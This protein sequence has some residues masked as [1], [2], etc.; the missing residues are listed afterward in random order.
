MKN[1]KIYVLF[2]FFFTGIIES[3]SDE[4][5]E[6]T[7]YGSLSEDTYFQTP[8]AA[9]KM[10]ANCYSPMLADFPFSINKGAMG[11]EITDDADVGGSDPGDRP[12]IPNVATGRPLTSNPL[13]L[14]TWT[15]RYDGI[16]KCNYGISGISREDILLR[17]AEGNAVSEGTKLRYIAEI[18][19]LRAFYY[20]DLVTAFKNVPLLTQPASI[21]DKNKI[22]KSP[23]EALRL[24]IL[25]DLEEGIAEPNLPRA[26][27]M[28]PEELGRVSKDAVYAFKVRVT[29]FFAGLIEQGLMEGDANEEY[30][31]ARNA[32][33]EVIDN[34]G[35]ELMNDYQNLF[36]GDYIEGT[37]SKECIF[38]VLRT[39]IGDIWFGGDAFAIMN[40]GR[41]EV[42][43]WGGNC[44]TR[45]L[46]AE[47][48][49]GDP[50]KLYTIISHLDT[51][52]RVS[53]LPEIHDYSGYYNDFNLQQSRKAFV[54]DKYR[55]E[56]ALERTNWSPYYIRY[57][58]VLL[59]YAEA[60]LKTSGDHQ[61]VADLINQVR[62]RAF[63]TT[64]KIDEEATYR[65]FHAE[66]FPIDDAMFNNTYKV[67]ASDD[68]LA[69][70]KHERR[71]ELGMESLR[72][73]D[74]LRW[75]D[76]VPVMNS[77]YDHYGLAN[78]GKYVTATSWPFPI[79]Q[80]E[81][82]RAGGSL[83]QTPNY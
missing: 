63:V 42:G 16:G 48:E 79:P 31:A 7:Q 80:V 81:I 30:L 60:L 47:F 22:E 32:A 82:D 20:F 62:Y 61:T 54:P 68:L 25:K 5:L 52:P 3:C 78:K 28:P 13:L 55:D 40:A 77:F 46:A 21:E 23:I 33:A 76:Y 43:G 8:D 71:V 34:G 57:A 74:L 10:V 58:D 2:L 24:Q 50:R 38:T 49:T 69:A 39:F 72:F 75:G 26:S 51:F 6:S 35:F 29:L 11:S 59:M 65:K 83:T 27:A 66:L 67:Q 44:P 41:N 12:Q 9:M 45:D 18:K 37:Q 15:N 17:D 36:R 73:I 14:E 53:G 70:L 4:F 64:S 1:I 19:F 56:S